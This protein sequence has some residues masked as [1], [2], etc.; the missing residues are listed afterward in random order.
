[1]NVGR[2]AATSLGRNM[3]AR[4]QLPISAN[5]KPLS[6]QS[7]T[8]ATGPLWELSGHPGIP[9]IA[10]QSRRKI[11]TGS[12]QAAQFQRLFGWNR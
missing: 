5:S 3:D 12:R 10:L 4:A 1:M 9:A 6:S 8:S 7:R 11:V 2:R